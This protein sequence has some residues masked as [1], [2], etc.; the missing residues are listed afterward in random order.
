[1]YVTV[2]I[3]YS[4]PMMLES[5]TVVTTPPVR[6][7]AAWAERTIIRQAYKKCMLSLC[8]A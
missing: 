8:F 6:R 4:V 3:V 1:M 2:T 5:I 7:V